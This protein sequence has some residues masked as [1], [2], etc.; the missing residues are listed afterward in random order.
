[1][2]DAPMPDHVRGFARGNTDDDDDDFYKSAKG[3]PFWGQD[4]DAVRAGTS[5]S[6]YKDIMFEDFVVGEAQGA[7]PDRTKE[8]LGASDRAI[9]RSRRYLLERVP[10]DGEATLRHGVGV[11]YSSLA[12]IAVI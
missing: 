2:P 12:G 8:F 5:F 7:V 9:M 6:G 4:R 3:Q 11:D 10:E 1:S